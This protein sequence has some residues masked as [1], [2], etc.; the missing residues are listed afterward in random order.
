MLLLGELLPSPGIVPTGTMLPTADEMQ[1]L[2]ERRLAQ[3][4]AE[5]AI[6]VP[7]GTGAEVLTSMMLRTVMLEVWVT[8]VPATSIGLTSTVAAAGASNCTEALAMARLARELLF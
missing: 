6:F 7:S 4:I 8:P 2:L 5:S 1:A 3:S